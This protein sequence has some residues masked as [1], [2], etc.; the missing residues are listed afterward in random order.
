[1]QLSGLFIYP[2]KSLRG[3]SVR[4]AELTPRGL[5]H[6]R[7]F[8]VAD[9]DGRFVTQREAPAMATVSTAL[10]GDALVLSRDGVE[11]RVPLEPQGAAGRVVRCWTDMVRAM[12]VSDEADSF[13]SQALE[14][15][16]QLVYM[17]QDS[18]RSV[19]PKHAEP[20]DVVSFA[21]GFPYLL[22]G[23]ASVEE[24]NTRLDTPVDAGRFR[25]NLLVAGSEP[26]AEDSWGR[27]R[28]GDVEFVLPKGC[29]RCTVVNTD[30]HS[31]ARAKQPLATLAKYRPARKN[32]PIFGQ[33]ALARGSGTLRVGD[34][35]AVLADR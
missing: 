3:L 12:H 30:Q 23:E 16:V 6:D 20:D 18:R 1:M 8:M 32:A 26:Y 27:V 10:S 35:I 24:L 29:T 9:P 4:E 14:R 7:R 19:D 33:N 34:R 28:I 15:D 11:C 25:P 17:P 5:K 2:V 13:L 21:D 22:L 31:G